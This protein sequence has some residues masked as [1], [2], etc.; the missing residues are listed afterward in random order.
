MYQMLPRPYLRSF[1]LC[2]GDK[3]IKTIWVIKL[4]NRAETF[5]WEFIESKI[6]SDDSRKKYK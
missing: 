5:V 4:A 1:D 6:M 2:P 3:L